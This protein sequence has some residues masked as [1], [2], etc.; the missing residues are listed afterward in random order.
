[1]YLGIDIGT[2]SVKAVLLTEQG[3]LAASASAPLEVS[4]PA[5]G[6]SEQDPEAWW[7]AAVRAINA[8]PDTSRAKV[9]AVGL[10]GQ[11]HGA[12]LLDAQE[13]PLR[14]AILW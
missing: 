13:R 1:M 10:S 9:R 4:R 12:T 14:P 2:S 5:P 8:L 6:F 3:T 7:Q 11:M